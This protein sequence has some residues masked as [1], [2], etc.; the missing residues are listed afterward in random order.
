MSTLFMQLIE[1]SFT[2]RETKP[3][4]VDV[5]GYDSEV[6]AF[7]KR[8]GNS[9]RK[10]PSKHCWCLA[11]DGMQF[12]VQALRNRWDIAYY[13]YA[14]VAEFRKAFEEK[15]HGSN[16][17][18]FQTRPEEGNVTIYAIIRFLKERGISLV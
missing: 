15:T 9:W 2:T 5:V 3:D 17:I 8:I 16:A 11:I 13:D 6:D 1:Q 10:T 18:Y 14:T 7:A 12:T 4:L